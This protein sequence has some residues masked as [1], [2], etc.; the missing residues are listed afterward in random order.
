MRRFRRS[1]SMARW[2][3]LL[4]LGGAALCLGACS[5]VSVDVRPNAR[6][7]E[8]GDTAAFEVFLNRRQGFLDPVQLDPS[9]AGTPQYSATI[10]PD[11][12]TG[13]VADLL[14]EVAPDA[15]I[16]VHEIDVISTPATPPPFI[17]APRNRAVVIVGP[18]GAEWILQFGGADGDAAWSTRVDANGD[19]YAATFSGSDYYVLRFENDGVLRWADP[20][21]PG[22]PAH[23][24]VDRQGRLV[25]AARTVYDGKLGYMIR[26]YLPGGFPEWTV[27]F[28]DD[29]RAQAVT[30]LATDAAGNVYVVGTTQGDLFGLNPDRSFTNWEGWIAAYDSAGN[31]LWQSQAEHFGHDSYEN[32]AADDAGGVYVRG[33]RGLNTAFVRKFDAAS[34][35]ILGSDDIAAGEAY[36]Q[37]A[38]AVDSTGD[39]LVAFHR[40]TGSPPQPD[41]VLIKYDASLTRLWSEPLAPHGLDVPLDMAVDSSDAPILAGSRI[42]TATASDAAVVKLGDDGRPQW[43]LLIDAPF[44]TSAIGIDLDAAGDM[45]I[46]G[47][48]D[49]G[50][51]AVNRGYTDA[52][53][54]RIRQGGCKL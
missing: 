27:R 11:P 16:G 31:P 2:R 42:V 44:H 33:T 17:G 51:G 8:A 4:L 38:L 54:G 32:V 1:K 23:L 36:R 46:A 40:G 13:N 26:R 22:H 5:L 21:E 18:C 39:V 53:L 25:V 10:Q 19:I 49:G 43:S 35:A 50:F 24:D 12:A 45:Y 47:D 6:T 41:P 52:W 30:D 48:T 34:G 28:G 29:P 7:V 37:G 15:P 14:V 9:P 20:I 3:A